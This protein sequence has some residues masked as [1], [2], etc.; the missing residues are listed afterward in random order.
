M[1]HTP[2]AATFEIKSAE[3]SMVAFVPKTAVLE[4]L[5]RDLTRQFSETPDFFDN[6]PVLI[7]VSVLNDG[8]E[9]PAVDFAGL[10]QLLKPFRL[11]AVAFRGAR[12]DQRPAAQLAGLVDGSDVRLREGP[13][14]AP[15]PVPETPAPAPAELG[16]LVIDKPLRSGQQVYARGRDLVMLA[17]VNPGAEVIADGSIHVYAALR[18]KAIAGARGL[19]SARIFAQAMEP[20]LVSIAGVYRTRENPLPAEVLGKP[21]CVLLQSGQQG[22]RLLIQPLKT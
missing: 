12:E 13:A 16:A 15:A 6:D 5:G 2:V 1:L 14:A 11:R 3:L 7:D 9:P 20:E 21:A 8:A 19:V 4:D 10:V 17:M 22:D 18:G